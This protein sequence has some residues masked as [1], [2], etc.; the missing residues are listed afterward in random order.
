VFELADGVA[1][2]FEISAAPRSESPLVELQQSASLAKPGSSVLSKEL[3]FPPA[4]RARDANTTHVI[5]L[6]TA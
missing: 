4:S 6:G 3:I 5:P 1:G 2:V